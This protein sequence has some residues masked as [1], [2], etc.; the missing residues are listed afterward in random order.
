MMSN[1]EDYKSWAGANAAVDSDV[2]PFIDG[3]PSVS[4]VRVM[5]NGEYTIHIY[6]GL[7]SAKWHVIKGSQVR[8]MTQAEEADM[9][10]CSIDPETNEATT[11]DPMSHT[12]PIKVMSLNRF[13]NLSN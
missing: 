9:P 5:D 3:V 4:D 8:L 2:V 6:N 13:L 12:G 11:L 7:N 10:A 1:L